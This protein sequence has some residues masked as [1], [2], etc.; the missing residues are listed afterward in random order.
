MRLT[1]QSLVASL[2]VVMA[3][4][5]S[6]WLSVG[7]ALTLHEAKAKGYVGEMPNGY[8]GIVASSAPATAKSLMNNI[9]QKRKQKYQDIA[10]RNGTQLK[11][12]EALAGKTAIKR[13]KPGDYIKLPSGQ[14]R[15]K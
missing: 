11:A 6:G 14:W 8:L 2:F 15:R 10:R 9:N 7:F 12:V 13:T 1:V 4:L 5:G 3:M